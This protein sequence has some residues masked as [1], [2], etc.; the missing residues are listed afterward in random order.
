[1]L[2]P[3]SL[4]DLLPG[5]GTVALAIVSGAGG[6]ALLELWYKP[7]RDRRRAA[8]ALVAE[9]MLNTDLALLH[10]HARWKAVK[11]IPGDFRFS[12]ICW[13][14][15]AELISE[16]PVDLIKSVVIL[17]NRYKQ[18][19]E[20]VAFYREGLDQLEAIPDG[21]P[22]RREKVTKFLDSVIDVFNTGIDKSIDD[23]KKLLPTFMEHAN[24]PKGRITK[25]PPRDYAHVVNAFLNEREER[26]R[27]LGNMGKQPPSPDQPA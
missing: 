7:R 25:G 26:I 4:R 10:A 15:A 27:V 2:D 14:S 5:L 16:L 23:G 6:S 13:D 1:M 24:I 12:L 19:N 20:A 8:K 3:A 9:I 21:N 18:C 22:N 11:K 17:Y